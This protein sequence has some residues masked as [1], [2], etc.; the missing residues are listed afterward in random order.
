MFKC[1]YTLELWTIACFCCDAIVYR[2]LPCFPT[3]L[4]GS[5]LIWT[6]CYAW[7]RKFNHPSKKLCLAE[8]CQKEPIRWQWCQPPRWV[9][10]VCSCCSLQSAVANPFVLRILAAA[11]VPVC[12]IERIVHLVGFRRLLVWYGQGIVQELFMWCH[13]H[14]RS[15]FLLLAYNTPHRL[16][17]CSDYPRTNCWS[18][19]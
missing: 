1:T 15:S 8:S 5:I 16:L 19:Q 9:S 10:K 17:A 6:G 11:D 3:L 4:H 14:N 12:M 18:A 2:F 7:K 13:D